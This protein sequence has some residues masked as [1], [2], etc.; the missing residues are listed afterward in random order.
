MD[1]RP[2]L[3]LGEAG[4]IERLGETGLAGANLAF[5]RRTAAA[6]ESRASFGNIGSYY[7]GQEIRRATG[8]ER[9]YITDILF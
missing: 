1:P 4:Q 3:S 9:P 8:G 5:I 6:N 2:H 7:K